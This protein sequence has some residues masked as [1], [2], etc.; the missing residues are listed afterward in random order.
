MG[1]SESV[2]G[3][4]LAELAFFLVFVMLL[5]TVVA[6]YQGPDGDDIKKQLDE[7]RG[8]LDLEK[9]DLVTAQE[10]NER[11]RLELE[12]KRSSWLPSCQLGSSN[13]FLFTVVIRG[14]D[15]FQVLPMIGPVDLEGLRTTFSNELTR[16]ASEEC[17][18][19]VAYYFDPNLSGV[20]LNRGEG[21]LREDFYL[22]PLGAYP[23][24]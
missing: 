23:G 10:E 4:T 11:L 13:R 21:R 20:E 14:S 9:A 3:L 17:V 7:A 1:D 24:Q 12:D 8:Q 15:S 6:G 16:A 2:L 18:H 22:Q 5:L 19:A